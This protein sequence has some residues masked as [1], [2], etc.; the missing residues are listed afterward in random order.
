VD[1]GSLFTKAAVVAGGRVHYAVLPSEGD[2]RA[3]AARAL[4]QALARAGLGRESLGAVVAMGLGGTK[5]AGARAQ[6]DITCLGRGI[7][8]LFP[9][10]THVLD[11]GGNGTR[12]IR[13]GPAGAVR[14]F[15]VSGQCAAGS[16]RILEVVAHLLGVEVGE[17]GALSLRATHPAD[18]SA[19]CAV[20]AETEA[21][22]L[23]T[24]GTSR[25]DLLGGLHRS[26]AQKILALARAQ[27]ASGV[28]AVAGGG[29]KDAG[30]VTRLGETLGAL[31][32]PPE[33]MVVAALGGALLAG[34]EGG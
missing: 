11:V 5:V 3:A 24:R 17:L 30:L 22:S 15:S 14:D 23:L 26:L 18:F 25:E 20:F 6:S 29:G 2:Y 34:E 19:G 10:A 13:L 7:A 4:G 8:R 16:A 28:V 31:R 32:V 33:P 9:D 12:A 1:V 21:I 27:E